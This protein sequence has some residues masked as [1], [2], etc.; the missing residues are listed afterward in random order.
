MSGRVQLSLFD[1]DAAPRVSARRSRVADLE[2]LVER[3]HPFD[4]PPEPYPLLIGTSGGRTSGY[5]L[6]Q[7]IDRHGLE[8]VNGP[9]V[10]VCFT[11]T[12]EEHELTLDFL[13]E[14]ETRWG[15]NVVWLE[16][17]FVPFPPALLADES[18]RSLRRRQYE[19]RTDKGLRAELAA[20]MTEAGFPDRAGDILAGRECLNG[21][22]AYAVVTYETASRNREPFEEML[23]VREE[24]RRSVKGL[25]GCLP[26]TANNGMCTG[27][28]K[29]NVMARY[30]ADRF[31]VDKRGYAVALALR[32]DGRD[33]ER[34]G[35]IRGRESDGGLPIFPLWES[36][37]ERA[38]VEAFWAGQPFDLRIPGYKGNCRLCHLKATHTLQYLVRGDPAD[39][40][41]RA[42]WET[43]TGDRFARGKPSY[44]RMA[45][46]LRLFE[47]PPDDD[48]SGLSCGSGYCGTD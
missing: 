7:Y 23:A 24:Y 42:D 39:A 22:D 33:D 47:E 36:G 29:V 17:R 11:N 27:Q 19:N 37:V 15:V 5:Q 21:R 30:M 40:A 44:R 13:H 6:R 26:N 43:R 8:V 10:A 34:T 25:P 28:L 38:D 32:A 1:D 16:Y 2:Q 20:V 41:W 12:G 46:E 45:T 4:L 18:F 14:Q 31:G 35:A 48:A 3:A 9:R